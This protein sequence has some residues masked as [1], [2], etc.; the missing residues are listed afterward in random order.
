MVLFEYLESRGFSLTLPGT[1]TDL[2]DVKISE[3]AARSLNNSDLV[4][5]GVVS[6]KF[7]QL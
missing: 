1:S 2:L 6:E 5:R 7:G 3:T 4:G